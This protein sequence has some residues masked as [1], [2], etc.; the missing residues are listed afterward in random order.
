MPSDSPAIYTFGRDASRMFLRSIFSNTLI[1]D[2]A[3]R[4]AGDMDQTIKPRICYDIPSGTGNRYDGEFV[5]LIF[6]TDAGQATD[7][8]TEAIAH[9]VEGYLAHKYGVSKEVLP[10]THTYYSDPPRED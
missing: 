5:E 9:K 4:L 7:E 10:T 3:S 6:V 1:E 2:T 8:G